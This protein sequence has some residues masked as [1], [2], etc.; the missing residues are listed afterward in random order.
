MSYAPEL[1]AGACRSLGDSLLLA[2]GFTSH[3][4]DDAVIEDRPAIAVIVQNAHQDVV[5]AS[6]SQVHSSYVGDTVAHDPEHITATPSSA[7]S[8]PIRDP[9]PLGPLPRAPSTPITLLVPPQPRSPTLS[10]W[11]SFLFDSVEPDLV[12]LEATISAQ[13]ASANR[14]RSNAASQVPA[15]KPAPLFFAAR[16]SRRIN[17]PQLD[18]LSRPGWSGKQLN[19][20]QGS[21]SSPRASPRSPLRILQEPGSPTASASS[22]FDEDE[23]TGGIVTTDDRLLTPKASQPP[24]ESDAALYECFGR[25]ALFDMAKRHGFDGDTVKEVFTTTGDLKKTDAVLLKMREAAEAAKMVML[26]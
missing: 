15:Y 21:P 23:K 1:S 9:M 6:L 12:G 26:G 18:I 2:A 24:S 22:L 17:T 16:H 10:D 5:V 25:Q 11:R 19:N 3:Q 4:E 20:E 13:P 8:S 14:L 7:P